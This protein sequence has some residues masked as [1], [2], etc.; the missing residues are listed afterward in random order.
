MALSYPDEKYDV[1]SFR[2]DDK[3]NY[4]IQIESKKQNEIIFSTEVNMRQAKVSGN[5]Q[6]LLQI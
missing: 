6:D 1:L 2:T 4:T 5:L 3:N